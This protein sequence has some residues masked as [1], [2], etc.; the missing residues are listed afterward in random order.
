MFDSVINYL[1]PSSKTEN[2]K[3]EP[4]PIDPAVMTPAASSKTWEL[5]QQHRMAGA[6]FQPLQ[7]SSQLAWDA[8]RNCYQELP[9]LQLPPGFQ[10]P[11][12]SCPVPVEG[13]ALAPTA[14][15]LGDLFGGFLD[16]VDN[17][18]T[19][20]LVQY[21]CA[22]TKP[23]DHRLAAE[24]LA[25]S[26]LNPNAKEFT[27]VVR[28][29]EE[30]TEEEEEEGEDEEC[31]HT[32]E[33]L[34]DKKDGEE[35]N[36]LEGTQEE[37]EEEKIHTGNQLEDEVPLSVAFFS[38]E[39]DTTKEE[40]KGN[41]EKEETME[42]VTEEDEESDD[43]WDS[44]EDVC[45]QDQQIDPAE[46]EDLF[47]CGLM[48]TSLT[49]RTRQASQDLQPMAIVS[50]TSIATISLAPA[51]ANTKMDN[52]NRIFNETF[53]VDSVPKSAARVC[54]SDEET[55]E[56]IEEPE[57]MA[58]ELAEA[59]VGEWE[60]RKA[61]RERMERTLGPVLTPLHRQRMYVK[62]YGHNL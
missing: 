22:K 8:T 16:L 10:P 45:S 57:E 36:E 47:P 26:N 44:D 9:V 28:Q 21:V 53:S 56:V 23:S 62:I 54:F 50:F 19:N 40:G 48:V 13:V 31:I 30:E 17:L 32:L 60:Q 42:D 4:K 58:E 34:S 5:E 41:E 14:L 51:K 29:V 25:R 39:C 52:I 35:Q 12:Y 27:P 43:W 55:W 20:S 2:S 33:E 37:V 49:C 7:P 1:A 38:S 15:P 61:D 3:M 18:Y 24:V 11:P 6:W 46:F 59:R